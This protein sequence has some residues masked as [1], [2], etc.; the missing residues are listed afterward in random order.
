MDSKKLSLWRSVLK[1]IKK[2]TTKDQYKTWFTDLDIESFTKKNIKITVPNLFVKE[3]LSSNYIDTIAE[4]IYNICN[5]KPKI[6]FSC[7]KT[8]TLKNRGKY[9]KKRPYGDYNSRINGNYTFDNF[10][11]GKCNSIAHAAARSVLESP[12][13]MYNP[14]FIY[15]PTGIGKTHLLQSV[16]IELCKTNANVLFVMCEDM[17]NHLVRSLD[18]N[19][20]DKF[21]SLYRGVDVLLVDDIQFL[22][23]SDR[24]KEEFFHT[25]NALYNSQK[26]IIVASD[27]HPEDIPFIEKRL[28]S[29]FNWGLKCKLETPDFET[30]AA[31]IRKKTLSW[32]MTLPFDVVELLARNI[33]SNIRETEGIILKIKK[34]ASIDRTDVNMDMVQSTLQENSIIKKDISL[35][36]I[37][38]TI[39]RQFD[40]NTTKLLSKNRIKSV[41]LPR[42]I[43][44]YLARKLTDLSFNEIGGY[45]GGRDHS[46]VMYA[47]SKIKENK[48]DEIKHILN[49][50][51]T[52]LQ[53]Y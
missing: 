24:L 14:L 52:E 7:N 27:C 37:L 29:R 41:T 10:V 48:T 12:G 8:A 36:V 50:L 32:G 40:I 44:M 45:F 39:A 26:Q 28:I 9:S 46:T 20:I 49:K 3:C 30:N 23:N 6:G 21:R 34:K 18:N 25:F 38:N 5:S 42:Q 1:D 19:E 4:S 51:E 22:A 47:Y 35:E 13:Y 11:V 15:G 53:R 17:I 31:I 16:Y 2:K 33:T 43:G